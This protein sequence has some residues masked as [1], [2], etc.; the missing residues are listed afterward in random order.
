[1]RAAATA[2][3][4]HDVRVD[5]DQ[6]LLQDGVLAGVGGVVGLQPALAVQLSREPL[7]TGHKVTSRE[8]DIEPLHTGVVLELARLDTV[9]N[10]HRHALV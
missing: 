2:Q 10:C 3:V 9:S 6:Q 5:A 1:M 7:L 8:R 4:D